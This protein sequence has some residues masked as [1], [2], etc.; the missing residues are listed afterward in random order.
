[1]HAEN[2]WPF[3]K[4]EPIPVPFAS[5][6]ARLGHTH[7]A[8][9]HLSLVQAAL[10]CGLCDKRWCEHVEAAI[11][12]D[13]DTGLLIVANEVVDNADCYNFVPIF[14]APA[15]DLWAQIRL[16]DVHRAGVREMW[17]AMPIVR[18]GLP[19]EPIPEESLGYLMAVEGR[20]AMRDA[21][22]QQ[23]RAAAEPSP[24]TAST[25][26]KFVA[27]KRRKQYGEAGLLTD[28]WN[29]FTIGKCREC[30]SYLNFESD[31]PDVETGWR[32]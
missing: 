21:F 32:R 8:L 1:M 7:P 19:P 5:T 31:V 17:L 30:A 18:R 9:E 10:F 26:D 16:A 3:A 2:T 13:A 25:H 14:P 12:G 27:A 22:I 29:L 20:R 24:C 6:T 15:L 23:L 11:K 28:K 4:H